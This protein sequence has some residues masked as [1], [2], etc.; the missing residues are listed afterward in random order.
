MGLDT[1][2]SRSEDDIELNDED[3]QAFADANI[4]LGGGIFSGSGNDGSFRGKVYEMMILE[5]TEQSLHQD[6]IPPETVREMYNALL[7]C[8][9]IE[10]AETFGRYQISP[11]EVVELRKFFKVCSE[12]GLGLINWW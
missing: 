8:D 4:E 6:W 12:R 7:V 10:S 9:P 5:I 3:K 1:F 11:N 2:A